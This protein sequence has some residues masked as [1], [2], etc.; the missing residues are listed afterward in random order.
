LIGVLVLHLLPER[1]SI[2]WVVQLSPRA[3]GHSGTLALGL[4]GP[5]SPVENRTS[6]S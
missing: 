1:C 5:H 2:P 3:G 4:G 6:E